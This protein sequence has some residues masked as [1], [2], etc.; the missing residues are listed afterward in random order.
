M[1][2]YATLTSISESPLSEGLIYV[3]S[4]DGLIQITENG[5]ASWSSAGALPK[6]PALSFIN[7]IET[8]SHEANTVFAAVDAHKTGD[9]NPYL[10]K[11]TDRGRTWKS[12][13]GDLPAS[14]IVWVIKQDHI[15]PN[16]L[17]IGTEYGIYFSPNGG[18][19]WAKLSGGVPTISFR[20]IELHARDNDIVG[21]TFGRG[22]YVLDDYSS[23]REISK[24]VQ[25]NKSEL[26]SV[27]DAWWYVPYEPMQ[28]KGMPTLGTTSF[29]AE[30]P[31]FGAVFTYYLHN[32]PS[33]SKE[34]RQKN[35]KTLRQKN[36][37]IPFPGWEELKEES[38][39]NEARV[40]LLVSDSNG[41][42]VRWLEGISAK[43]LH[44]ASWDLRYPSPDPISLAKPTF[45][46]PWAGVSKG[47][48]AAPGKYS[49]ELFLMHNGTFQN[50]GMKQ[51]FNVKP[52]DSAPNDADFKAVSEFQQRTSELSRQVSSASKEMDGINQRIS[53]MRVALIKAPG[54]SSEHFTDLDKLAERLARLKMRLSG[55]P[56]RQKMS[57]STAPSISSRI[58]QVVYGHWNTRQNPTET[59][60]RNIE[61]A[62]N[63]FEI[64]K[65]DLSNYS[66]ELSAYEKTLEKAGAPW[67]PG[68]KIE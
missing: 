36:F 42:S 8:S 68:R 65:G 25:E 43:G 19:N 23:L 52:V 63:D 7:D 67:T 41:Q 56:I 54:A 24:V 50:L 66:S 34:D 27:R 31:P 6:V 2:K 35:E 61:I 47:P 44:R 46:P 11:S 1:S 26:F 53:H 18:I 57:E 17:I 37:D 45:V 10:F 12:I 38:Y 58:G 28:A 14:T 4:D 59:H 40:L 48:L 32:I 30:N 55:D 39:E 20:D 33:T 64:F 5:G 21:A 16:L 49:V 15:D 60:K 29:V 22:I 51:E 9:L 13:K 62:Q 3:G